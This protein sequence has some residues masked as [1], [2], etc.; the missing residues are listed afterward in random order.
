MGAD[1][2]AISAELSDQ[3]EILEIKAFNVELNNLDS[4]VKVDENVVVVLYNVFQFELFDRTINDTSSHI[5]SNII[6]NPLLFHTPDF[7]V[8]VL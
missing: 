6:S 5:L 1:N 3:I 8:V 4:L 7:V 2:I